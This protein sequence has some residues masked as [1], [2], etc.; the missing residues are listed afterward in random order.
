MALNLSIPGQMTKTELH[1]LME[2]ASR[3]RPGGIIVKAVVFMGFPP[4][5]PPKPAK[6]GHPVLRGPLGK[7]QVDH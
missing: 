1:G 7:G 4:G 3:V 2:L 5:I 6:R